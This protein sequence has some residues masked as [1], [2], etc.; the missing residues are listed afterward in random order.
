MMMIKL[1][2]TWEYIES[3]T[4]NEKVVV[5]AQNRF[6]RHSDK[7]IAEMIGMSPSQ[8]NKL[9]WSAKGKFHKFAHREEVE[10]QNYGIR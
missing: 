5:E 9:K 6:P 3:L 1:T 8:F 4:F 2:E 10:A 7:V